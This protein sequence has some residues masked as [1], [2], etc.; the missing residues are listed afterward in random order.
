MAGW[1][2][3]MLIIPDL[4]VIETEDGHFFTSDSE[5][6]EDSV[7]DVKPNFNPTCKIGSL[8]RGARARIVY[9]TE[10]IDCVIIV[11]R[12]ETTI[13]FNLYSLDKEYIPNE[14]PAQEFLND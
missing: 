14:T 5:D 4:Y 6:I 13:I 11:V 3:K 10:V 1:W 2:T 12:T 7:K 8:T 9:N